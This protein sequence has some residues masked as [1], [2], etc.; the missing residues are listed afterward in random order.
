[1]DGVEEGGMGAV[2]TVEVIVMFD[3][4]YMILLHSICWKPDI[5]KIIRFILYK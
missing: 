1:M 3:G 5:L 4:W 2:E